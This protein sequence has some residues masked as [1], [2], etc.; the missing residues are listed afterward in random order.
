MDSE[1]RD[2]FK[3]IALAQAEQPDGS[4]KKQ[5]EANYSSDQFQAYCLRRAQMMFGCY[6]KDEAQNPEIYC[7]AISATLALYS[8]SVVDFVTDPRSGIPSEKEWLPNVAEVRTYCTRQAQREIDLAK[9]K[10][11][12]LKRPS[13]LDKLPPNLFVPNDV[14]NYHLM[15]ERAKTA[16]PD[17]YRYENNRHM[18]AGTY[19]GQVKSGLWVPWIWWDERFKKTVA[20]A[21]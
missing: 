13:M 8:K 19:A 4:Q 9:P 10:M 6:R 18:T 17:D 2:H 5:N 20:S 11:Q 1:D 3:T 16:D 21:E 12:P 15:V 14:P 7:A